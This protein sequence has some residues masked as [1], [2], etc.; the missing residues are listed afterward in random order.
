[1]KNI[2]DDS[3]RSCTGCSVC[4]VS[5]PPNAIKIK[6]SDDGFYIPFVD[7]DKCTE[8]GLCKKACYKFDDKLKQGESNVLGTY[9]A[10]TTN[11]DVLK[12]TSSGG[13]SEVLA[14][15]L[16][17]KG[18]KVLGCCYNY[19]KDIAETIGIDSQE[20]LQKMRGSKYF[21][22]SVED[23]FK[24]A[25]LDKSNQKYA[26]FGTPCQIYAISKYLEGREKR[27][28][29]ILI[30]LFCH[31]TPSLNLWSKYA[32]MVKEK[33]SVDSFDTI[34]FRSKV[35]GWHKFCFKFTKGQKVYI[36]PPA[37][38]AFYT[39][40]FDKSAFNRACYDCKLRN[41][42]QYT[43]IRLGDFWGYRYDTDKKGVSAVVACS[44]QGNDLILKFNENARVLNVTFNEM[45]KGQSYGRTHAIDEINRAF[46][47]DLLKSDKK[48]DYIMVEYYSRW[49]LDKKVKFSFK[50]I[51]KRMPLSITGRLKSIYHR[52]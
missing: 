21:Q 4:S 20:E 40:F 9:S 51:I 27:K 15:A 35:R 1:M 23:A 31:G 8:C 12:K 5:C 22:S 18:Y 16:L 30:D 36:S 34:E 44:K 6:L 37:R 39:I 47:L 49:P 25:L 13:I 17:N 38:D 41:T 52:F 48:M 50:N 46:T 43:D 24:Q 2:N 28:N 32:D 11:S 29:F 42:T 45:I 3:C 19:E 33:M 10:V 26:I 7:E 14:K